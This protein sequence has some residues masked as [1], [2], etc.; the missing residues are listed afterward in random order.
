MAKYVIHCVDDGNE[1]ESEKFDTSLDEKDYR[2]S[3]DV[4]IK[5]AVGTFLMGSIIH[6]YGK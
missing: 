3:G 4:L 5:E 1:L 6:G 2:E